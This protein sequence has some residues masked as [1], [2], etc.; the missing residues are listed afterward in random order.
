[1]RNVEVLIIRRSGKEHISIQ[2]WQYTVNRQSVDVLV[3]L[4]RKY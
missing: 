3:K 1:M 2:T 4:E